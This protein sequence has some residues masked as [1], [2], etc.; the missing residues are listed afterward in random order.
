MLKSK[1]KIGEEVFAL[2]EPRFLDAPVIIGRVSRCERN[3][4]LP[5]LWDITV[6]PACDIEKLEDVAVIIMNQQK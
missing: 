4:E 6:E 3:D 5:S 2:K 1:A